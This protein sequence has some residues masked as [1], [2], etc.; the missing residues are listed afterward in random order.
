MAEPYWISWWILLIAVLAGNLL[1]TLLVC[2]LWKVT[3]TLLSHVC[4]TIKKT[5][6][7]LLLL[8]PLPPL[9]IWNRLTLL[10]Q[11]FLSSFFSLMVL[12][13]NVHDSCSSSHFHFCFYFPLFFPFYPL[14]PLCSGHL[15]SSVASSNATSHAATMRRSTTAPTWGSSPRRWRSRCQNYNTKNISLW[16]ALPSSSSYRR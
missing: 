6:Q 14:P 1:L 10:V 5:M 8:S 16:P 11:F 9:D 15:L 3:H 4:S 13:S 12:F 7:Q 2:L